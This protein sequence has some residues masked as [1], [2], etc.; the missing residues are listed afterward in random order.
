MNKVNRLKGMLRDGKVPIGIFI[1]LDSSSVA[2]AMAYAGFDFVILDME[3]SP[4]NI[5]TIHHMVQATRGTN[6]APLVRVPWNEDWLIKR[7]LDAGA[8]GVVVPQVST[9]EEALK[10]VH[11]SKYFPDGHRGF[12]PFGA[13]LRW[14]M[15]LPEYGDAANSE[16]AVLTIIENPNGVQNIDEIASVPG[17]DIVIQGPADLAAAMGG[18]KLLDT[19]QHT[20][21]LQRIYEACKRTGV[22]VAAYVA[23]HEAM[24]QAIAGGCDAI[25]LGTDVGLL[26]GAAGDILSS[27]R[28]ARGY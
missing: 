1:T 18:L 24:R 27:A 20:A 14:G 23:T 7:A 4:T 28:E 17:I 16:V 8:Y 19:P 12:G 3:H 11:A 26:L 2:E 22:P 9:K 25:I 5:E 13:A 21:A 10:A 15:S 6:T